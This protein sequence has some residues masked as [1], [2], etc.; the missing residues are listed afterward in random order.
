MSDARPGAPRQTIRGCSR[1]GRA[2]NQPAPETA[3]RRLEPTVGSVASAAQFVGILAAVLTSG[4]LYDAGG[5]RLLLTVDDL[6][7][8]VFVLEGEGLVAFQLS[9]KPEW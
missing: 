6:I 1:R 9:I 5:L 7:Y 8:P 4:P 2:Y 3:P